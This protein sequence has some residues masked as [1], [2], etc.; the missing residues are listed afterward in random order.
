MSIDPEFAFSQSSKLMRSY[1]GAQRK[2]ERIGTIMGTVWFFAGWFEDGLLFFFSMSLTMILLVIGAIDSVIQTRSMGQY[3][4]KAVRR[5]LLALWSNSMYISGDTPGPERIPFFGLNIEVVMISQVVIATLLVFWFSSRYISEVQSS[6]FTV[7]RFT[8][9]S[10]RGILR[11]AILAGF[12]YSLFTKNYIPE[13]L[14]IYLFIAYIAEPLIYMFFSYLDQTISRADMVFGSSKLP[15][16]ALRESLLSNTILIL[17]TGWFKGIQGSEWDALRALYL[18]VTILVFVWSFDVIKEF[19]RHVLGKNA[20]GQFLEHMPDEI[21][22]LNLGEKLGHVIDTQTMI[23]VGKKG[24]LKLNAGSIVIP[25]GEVQG[26]IKA[27]I[28]GKGEN[29]INQAGELSSQLMDGIS[30]A[31]ISKK[32]FKKAVKDI[33]P[34]RMDNINLENLELPSLETMVGL[35]SVLGNQMA[36]WVDNIK[37][38]L[39]R[40]QL[41]NYGISEVDGNETVILPGIKVQSFGDTQLVNVAGFIRVMETP[42]ITTV[43]IGSWLSVVEVPKFTF[44]TLP[45]ITIFDLAEGGSAVDIF[46]FKI[47]DGISADRLMEFKDALLSQLDRFESDMHSRLGRI[48]ADKNANALLS[49]SWDGE[50]KPLVEGRDRYFGEHPALGAGVDASRRLMPGYTETA[51]P[52][53]IIELTGIHPGGSKDIK[54]EKKKRSVEVN[55]QIGKA[56]SKF[57]SVKDEMD[58]ISDDIE[59]IKKEINGEK[60]DDYVIYDAD[61]EIVDDDD[62]EVMDEE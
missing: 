19:N 24:D 38:E 16:V 3:S 36:G 15:I 39:G 47:G 1:F 33:I 50:F 57:K 8:V 55:I 41:S 29:I 59:S 25:I 37:R 48:L 40:F 31:M 43:R 46:G 21:S 60:E 30:T 11:G 52:R 45:G 23:S 34:Q 44:V 35:M 4:G 12:V 62:P 14:N 10:I 51:E 28:I 27:I 42:E 17:F 56:K 26:M 22:E 20:L 61:Y 54:R 5:L 9:I 53:K 32:E 7:P 13:S 2:F 6:D 18:L 49:V 58:A